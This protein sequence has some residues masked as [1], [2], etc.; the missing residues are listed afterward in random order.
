MRIHL[1]LRTVLRK[2]SQLEIEK[3]RFKE[4]LDDTDARVDKW[5]KKADELFALA[6][7]A[8]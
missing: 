5:M 2:Q 1:K 6:R 7:D 4:L 3:K 8:V